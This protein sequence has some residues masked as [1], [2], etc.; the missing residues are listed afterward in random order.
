[1]NAEFLA[2]DWAG[3]G[4][5]RLV[6]WGLPALVLV[7]TGYLGLELHAWPL[8]LLWMGVACVLNARRCRRLHC[9]FTGPFFIAMS[10]MSL[11]H[12]LKLVSL[13]PDGWNWLGG[14][15]IVGWLVLHYGIEAVFG[16]YRKI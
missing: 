4:K 9:Y 2:N 10:A 12:G 5:R 6:I 7:V 15:I 13:G 1:M 3:A 11:L 14:T 16:K 8:L